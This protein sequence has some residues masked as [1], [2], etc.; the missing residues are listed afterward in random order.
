MLFHNSHR[1]QTNF[2]RAVKKGLTSDIRPSCFLLSPHTC[3]SMEHKVSVSFCFVAQQQP[4]CKTGK[5]S[6]CISYSVQSFQI[7]TTVF[8]QKEYCSQNGSF[9]QHFE[10]QLKENKKIPHFWQLTVSLLIFNF[11][12]SKMLKHWQC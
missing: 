5:F 4:L 3:F 9:D 8:K 2:W 10:D 11:G 7:G 1:I 12:I 6:V